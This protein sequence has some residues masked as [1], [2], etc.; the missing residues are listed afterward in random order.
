M[1][2]TV[3]VQRLAGLAPLLDRA[4]EIGEDIVAQQRTQR[5]RIAGGIGIDDHLESGAAAGKEMR[6]V[7][8]GIGLVDRGEPLGERRF[9]VSIAG[10]GAAIAGLAERSGTARAPSR[11]TGWSLAG[12]PAKGSRRCSVPVRRPSTLRSRN[13]RNTAITAKT[14]MSMN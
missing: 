1:P 2:T 7:E 3:V 13:T 12:A 6:I 8:A 4:V 11:R 9:G 10:S 14:M 5:R